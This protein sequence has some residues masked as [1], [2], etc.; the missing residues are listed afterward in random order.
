MG[1]RTPGTVGDIA[2]FGAGVLANKNLAV[3]CAGNSEKLVHQMLANRIDALRSKHSLDRA[4]QDA[5][6]QVT[7]ESEPSFAVVSLDLGGQPVVHGN[8][9]SFWTVATSEP[10]VR[11][12][13]IHQTHV[14]YEHDGQLA[15]ISI[16]PPVPLSK[17][18]QHEHQN[19]SPEQASTLKSNL[20]KPADEKQVISV[21]YSWE[22]PAD[23]AMAALQSPWYTTMF[24]MQS[25][26]Y[27]DAIEFFQRI[28]RY[29]YLVV[30]VTTSSISSPMGLGSDS[31]P[32]NIEMWGKHDYLA[33]SQ[34]F[35][36][37][38]GLRLQEGLRG[39]YYCGTSCRGE[40]SDA[41]HLNQFCH[42]ECELAGEL[43]DGIAVA[44]GYIVH[45]TRSLLRKYA[46]EITEVAG[47]TKHIED[48]L[49]L[50]ASLGGRFPRVPLDEALSL[51]E[52][53]SEMWRYVVPER[54]ELGKSL[55]RKGE[56]MLIA[57]YGGAVWLTEMHHQS[58]PFY[59]AY[60]DDEKTK[61]CCADFLIGLGEIMGCGARHETAEQV[62][63]S[64]ARHE[65]DANQYSWYVDM[66]KLK[67]MKTVG[68][69]M[70][71]ERYLCWIMQHMDV[72][73]IQV[74]LRLK[75]TEYS[76]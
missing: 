57:R 35:A 66:R 17:N 61:A 34:Q 13:S 65:V 11:N 8:S 4:V 45:T 28:Q 69:G 67:P 7:Q 74:I 15:K 60:L 49:H 26:M 55:T 25:T 19:T 68:W 63:N 1:H 46:K 40:D 18:R 31:E 14:F 23:H 2:V 42:F 50:R 30:P 51:P 53:T 52:I 10:V 32:L 5:V 29:E 44:E 33:D 64:L 3:V 76:P 41:A 6:D 48:V 37:E 47:T 43:D 27:H 75:G 20:A 22:S 36:L 72:R 21:P 39:V 16:Y 9:G 59:Q 12:P 71:I 70:G 58:V 73:D 54:P 24:R 38:W 56:L 62:L